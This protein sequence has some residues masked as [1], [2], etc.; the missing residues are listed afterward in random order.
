MSEA[1][2]V[3]TAQIVAQNKTRQGQKEFFPS[4]L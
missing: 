3:F 1:L 2:V 4:F